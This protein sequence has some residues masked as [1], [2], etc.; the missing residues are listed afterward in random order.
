V[1]ELFVFM[2]TLT[3]LVIFLFVWHLL[4]S[5]FINVFIID[6]FASF[7]ASILTLNKKDIKE[8]LLG[9]P[10]DFKSL[11]EQTLLEKEIEF[12]PKL[13]ECDVKYGREIA[14]ILDNAFICKFDCRFI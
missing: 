3:Y 4:L 13:I 1:E 14:K 9:T 11:D 10:K 2:A 8:V 12:F 5:I 6:L 7:S